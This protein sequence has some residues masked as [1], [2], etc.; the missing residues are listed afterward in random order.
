MEPALAIRW[1]VLPQ[2]S[3]IRERVL[4]EAQDGVQVGVFDGCLLAVRLGGGDTPTQAVALS[5]VIGSVQ[6]SVGE[7]GNSGIR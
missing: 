5:L 6:D 3:R 2:P 1:R 4:S 7:N